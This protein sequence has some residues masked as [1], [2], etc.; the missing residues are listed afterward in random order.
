MS[1]MNDREKAFEN[2]FAHDAELQFKVNAR[3]NKLLGLWIA[4]KL[5][6]SGAEAEAY[7]K[8]VVMSDFEKPGFDDVLHKIK[9]DVTAARVQITKEE[10]CAAAERLLVEAKAQVMA[11]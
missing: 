10:I 2:K 3:R 9:N 8:D 11:E 6:K 5:G 7:A 1:A 4:G